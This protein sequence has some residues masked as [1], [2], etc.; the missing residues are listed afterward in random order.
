MRVDKKDL[1]YLQKRRRD[2]VGEVFEYKNKILRGIFYGKDN[3]I[4]NMFKDGFL[5]ELMEKELIPE[6]RITS[7]EVD[8]YA[9][10]LEH[11]RID[12]ITY[13][14]EWTF[15]M[16]KDSALL[17]LQ[18]AKIAKRYG[19]NMKDCHGLNILIDRYK[20]LFID[21]GSFHFNKNGVTGW[22]P[23]QE[24]LRF[25]YYPLSMWAEGLSFI[26]KMSIFSGNLT[27]HVEY[28]IYKSPL[29]RCLP[30]SWKSC[31]IN[32]LLA[33]SILACLDYEKI[34]KKVSNKF[35]KSALKFS[36]K[37]VNISNISLAQNLNKLENKIKN[38]KR[39]KYQSI[40]SDYHAKISKKEKRFERIIQ[41][42]N[43]YFKD[44]KTAI[45]I[46]GNQ[47]KFSKKILKETNIE[48]VICL[49]FDENAIDY[50]YLRNKEEKLNIF[51]VNYN[52][53]APII[54]STYP[55]PWERFKSDV[56][57]G[58][59]LLH[60]LLLGQGFS[61]EDILVEFKKYTNKYIC[62]EFMPRGLWTYEMGNNYNVPSWYNTNWF[63]KY[64]NK[65]FEVLHK[66]Q[67]AENYIVYLGK[68]RKLK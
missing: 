37:I 26:S 8:G 22:E 68:V 27:P 25:Y 32:L 66:E 36:K 35:K 34:E 2:D 57:I 45:D 17:V 63:E 52:F 15:E 29:F 11:K 56:C 65:H 5:K 41:L 31:L 10:V 7:F 38:I 12:I 60:H 6:T 67:L 46:G 9:L 33:P 28:Y 20:P 61:L 3:L 64:F 48:R 43:L 50:G 39:K 13:P 51:F 1:K 62:I 59:A 19:Y 30:F 18:I 16:L 21:L 53:M 4:I 47:G 14:Q 55:P 23:F 58:L 44:A 24:F 40:W 42:I 49:D 54:K